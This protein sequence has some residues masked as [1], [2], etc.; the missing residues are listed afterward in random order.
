MEKLKDIE[1][2]NSLNDTQLKKIKEI[3]LFKNFDKNTILFF[4]GEKPKYFYLL[5]DGNVKVYKIDHKGNE[6]IVHNF[7]GPTLVA[8][9]A[10]LDDLLF[11]ANCI[12]LENSRFALIKKEEF[13]HILKNDSEISFQII[14]SLAK[15]I[16]YMNTFI[17]SSLVFDIDTR[18]AKYINKS[19]E[20][21]KSKKNK[22]IA[23]ELNISPETFSRSLK[24]FKDLEIIDKNLN[25][26]NKDKLQTFIK[27]NVI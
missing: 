10:S 14:K 8:E 22:I 12:C 5:L 11:P 25:L 16:R 6:I 26:L 15:K 3:T 20:E 27:Q 17:D 24:K 4:E 19:P 9:T 21:F 1:L 23:A 18:I 13:H 7:V 2:F